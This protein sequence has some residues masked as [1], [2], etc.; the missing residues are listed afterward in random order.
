MNQTKPFDLL[1]IDGGHEADIPM[2]DL[3]NARPLATRNN[4]VL[5]D[6]TDSLALAHTWQQLVRAGVQLSV[7]CEH[8]RECVK[9][10]MPPSPL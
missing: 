9:L 5:F 2:L 7:G 10:S 8:E 6:D 4:V 3:L 1:H